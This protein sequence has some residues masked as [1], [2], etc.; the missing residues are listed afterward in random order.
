MI[1][2][3]V[4]ADARRGA[5]GQQLADQ[6][7]ADYLSV[8]TGN[9]GC[10]GNH[11]QVWKHHVANPA[12]WNLT[13]EDDAVVRHD[14]RAQLDAAL[15][16]APTDIVSLY[17]GGGYIDDARSGATA[18]R[19]HESGVCW[20]L[21]RGRVLHAVAVAVRGELLAR[22]VGFLQTT[23]QPIDVTLSKW[24]RLHHRH[25]A[26]S[27]PSLVDHADTASLVHRFRRAPRKA[28]SVGSRQHWSDESVYM[29]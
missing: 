24:A 2:I 12:D 14:F 8:D 23:R 5:A 6:V 20:A 10:L 22:M 27:V 26:Y 9:L 25:V 29:I 11:L 18:L 4:V 7:G 17:W 16:A 19:A 28:W 3:G 21:T 13:L 15:A 1:R